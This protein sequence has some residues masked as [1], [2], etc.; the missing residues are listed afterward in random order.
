MGDSKAT[1]YFLLVASSIN[2]VLDIVFVYNFKM[3]VAGAAIATDIAQAASCIAGVIYMMKKYPLC[4][5]LMR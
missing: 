2:V 3:G 1:L 4:F 5:P